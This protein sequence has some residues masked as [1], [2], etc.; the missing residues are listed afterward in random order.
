M[1]TLEHLEK[2]LEYLEEHYISGAY[3]TDDGGSCAVGSMMRV[4]GKQEIDDTILRSCRTII[5]DNKF[6][7]SK[8]VFG[9]R[10]VASII[11]L[12]DEGKEIVMAA[13]RKSIRKEKERLG[14]PLEIESTEKTYKKE[15]EYVNN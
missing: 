5:E 7:V 1:Q 4:R 14:I 2:T 8:T 10:E 15:V 3:F 6:S 9:G 12:N 11:R 13:I